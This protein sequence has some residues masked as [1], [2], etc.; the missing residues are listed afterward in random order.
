MLI[1][2]SMFQEMPI[3]KDGMTLTRLA[4]LAPLTPLT[5]HKPGRTGSGSIEER[6]ELVRKDLPATSRWRFQSRRGT[7][8]FD[9]VT[10]VNAP[11]QEPQQREILCPSVKDAHS[12]SP[13][14]ATNEQHNRRQLGHFA[15]PVRKGSGCTS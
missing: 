8:L 10:F 6:S 15:S 4:M 14:H 9:R 7:S 12:V 1:T 3:A 2:A 13:D 5:I 11:E